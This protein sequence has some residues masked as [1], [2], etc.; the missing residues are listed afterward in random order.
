MKLLISCFALSLIAGV[1][2]YVFFGTFLERRFGCSKER[3]GWKEYLM[4]LVFTAGFVIISYL[5]VPPYLFQPIRVVVVLGIIVQIFFKT[6]VGKNIALTM[7]WCAMYWSVN[8]I[9]VSIVYSI[10]PDY[11][12]MRGIEDWLCVGIILCLSLAVDHKC[13]DW[14]DSWNQPRWKRFLWFPVASLILTMLMTISLWYQEFANGTGLLITAVGCGV[15]NVLLLYFVGNILK[16]EDEVQ[17]MRLMQEKM[18]NQMEMYRNMQE[19]DL[20]Y[21]K[22]LHDYKNQL[23]C[24]QGMLKA[25]KAEE[26]YAYIEE[27]NGSIRQGEDCV[28]TNHL[29]VNTVLNQKYRYAK[30]RGITI[31]MAVNDLSGLTMS[32]EDVVILLVNLLDNAIEACEKLESHKV[33]QF[34]MMLEGGELTISVRNPMKETVEVRGKTIPTTKKDKYEHG[35]G[36]LNIHSIIEKNQGTSILECR[37]GWFCWIA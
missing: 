16:K 35:I 11:E 27:L 12:S 20:R 10:L 36:F 17:K 24:I 19:S 1:S 25:G 6:G 3:E 32:K 37:E 13:R 29:V 26:A 4:V 2:C 34:K 30:E 5:P 15:I 31:I 23:G 14:Q 9:S 21:R 33:I 28:N 7:F 18:Q 22:Y 8:L